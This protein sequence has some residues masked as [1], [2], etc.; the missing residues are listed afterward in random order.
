[1]ENITQFCWKYSS[2]IQQ[3]KNFE[4]R[5]RFVKVIAKSLVA[6]FFGTQCS[7]S[8]SS[9]RLSSSKWSSSVDVKLSVLALAIRGYKTMGC[10][11]LWL[12]QRTTSSAMQNRL[13]T[14]PL[15]NAF[16]HLSLLFLRFMC[17]KSKA[18]AEFLTI[19]CLSQQL[20]TLSSHNVS[21]VASAFTADIYTATAKGTINTR[22]KDPLYEHQQAIYRNWTTHKSLIS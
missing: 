20:W 16:M 6:S 2:S 12:S 3:W 18:I 8:S 9:W 14:Q 11:H 13:T 10:Y 5:L 15:T 7:T 22:L 1:V 4:N 17:N 19:T 21:N